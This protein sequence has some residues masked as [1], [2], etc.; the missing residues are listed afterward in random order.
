[1]IAD[2]GTAT[3]QIMKKLPEVYVRT[4]TDEEKEQL[5]AGTLTETELVELILKP[6]PQKTQPTGN[7]GGDTPGIVTPG[8]PEVTEVPEMNE[9]QTRIAGLIAEMYV[10]REGMSNKLDD[11]MEAAKS[12]YN[13]LPKS[14]RTAAK[15]QS[16]I[17]QRMNEASQLESVCDTKVDGILKELRELLQASNG[18]IGIAAEIRKAYNDEKTLKKSYFISQYS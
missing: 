12:E 2:K 3:E 4:P 7:D 8:V 15:K 5:H 9:L 17:L 18:D 16:I 6:L 10:L 1:M 13:A 14:E 11:I